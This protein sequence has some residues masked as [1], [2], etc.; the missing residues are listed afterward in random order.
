MNTNKYGKFY[1]TSRIITGSF[2]FYDNVA[3]DNSYSPKL[4]SRLFTIKTYANTNMK[5]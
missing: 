4:I 1:I 2:S 5:Y 3:S